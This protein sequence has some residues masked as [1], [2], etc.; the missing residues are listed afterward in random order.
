MTPKEETEMKVQIVLEAMLKLIIENT[1]KAEE[2]QL[3]A[4]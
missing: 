3:I 2:L 1:N 4:A